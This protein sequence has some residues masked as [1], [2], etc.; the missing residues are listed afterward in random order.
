M[1]LKQVEEYRARQCIGTKLHN[2]T[3][4]SIPSTSIDGYTRKAQRKT[5]AIDDQSS[6]V[7]ET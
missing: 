2:Y 3:K 5:S 4:K 6:G 7:H 1:K